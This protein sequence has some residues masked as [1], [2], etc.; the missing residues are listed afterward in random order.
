MEGEERS[1]YEGESALL[2]GRALRGGVEEYT[3]HV[4][5]GGAYAFVG[6]CA[7]SREK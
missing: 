3:E 4:R 2:G 7:R 1:G 6:R 5:A